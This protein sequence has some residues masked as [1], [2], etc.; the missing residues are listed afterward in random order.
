MGPCHRAAPRELQRLGL[1]L[2]LSGDEISLGARIVAVADAFEV[3]TAIRSY[4]KALSP[5]AARQESTRCA[6][7]QFDPAIVRALLNVSIGRVRW[8]IGPLSWVADVSLLARLSV[9]GHAL[10]TTTQVAVGAAAL[11][12]AGALA[13]HAATPTVKTLV[14]TSTVAL[15]APTTTNRPTT[16]TTRL[17]T[18]TTTRP[19]TTTTGPTSTTEVSTTTT[20]PASTTSSTPPTSLP[21][22]TTT[23]QAPATTTASQPVAPT[24]TV[25]TLCLLNLLCI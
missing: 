10:V 3:M 17:G 16:T 23:S 1:P 22:T 12:A 20:A 9:A 7:S 15:A 4:K 24:A 14:P 6:G 21:S 25:D 11:T 2:G 8:V 13:A 5:V 19:A 18:T